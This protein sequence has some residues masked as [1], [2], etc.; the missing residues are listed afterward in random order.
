MYLFLIRFFGPGGKVRYVASYLLPL[1]WYIIIVIII[2]IIIII[3]IS[4]EPFSFS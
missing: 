3:I 4:I 2:V 1:D